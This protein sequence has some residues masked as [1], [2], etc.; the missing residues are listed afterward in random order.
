MVKKSMH[1]LVNLWPQ[2]FWQQTI[3]SF[4]KLDL[5]VISAGYFVASEFVLIVWW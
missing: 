2:L 5:I 4:A 1:A 3:G